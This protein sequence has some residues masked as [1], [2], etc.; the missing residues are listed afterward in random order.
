MTDH[1]APGSSFADNL[2]ALPPA[3]GIARLELRDGAGNLVGTI[4]NQPGKTGSLRVYRHLAQQHA[5]ID[6]A[7]AREGLAL[8]AEHVAEARHSPGAHPNIDRLM[9]IAEGGAPLGV[10]IVSTS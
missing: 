9:T 4:E 1:D 6:A 5:V 2:A 3:D 10:R 7:A 8:F